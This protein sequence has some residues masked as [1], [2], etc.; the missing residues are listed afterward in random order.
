MKP[1]NSPA[2]SDE[3]A[4]ATPVE[5]PAETPTAPEP[6]TAPEQDEDED[7]EEE[8]PGEQETQAP[9]A[10]GAAATPQRLTA[11]DRGA[12]RLLGKGDLVARVELAEGEAT[13]LNAEVS[14]LTALNASLTAEVT[15]HK[16]ETP[17]KI[18][19]A[20]AGRANEVSKNVAAELQGLGLSPE[21]A[22]GKVAA[23]DAEKIVTRDDAQAA[24][25]N[26]KTPEEK[27]EIYN[28][29]RAL[30]F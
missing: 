21:A 22:P 2:A 20:A 23:E 30:L 17:K 13:R 7:E 8:T 18:A 11:F 14:R 29:H 10:P 3:A 27:R 16:A 28:Q 25:A 1:I 9:E 12:L 19:A 24:Y 6:S 15:K 26:A 4:P 5:Q